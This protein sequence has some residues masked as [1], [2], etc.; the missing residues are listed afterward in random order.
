MKPD[1]L[2]VPATPS[3]YKPTRA[4]GGVEVGQQ[5]DVL[6]LSHLT[7]LL[8][9]GAHRSVAAGDV[10][11]PAGCIDINVIQDADQQLFAEIVFA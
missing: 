7:P 8:D 10:D 1:G 6:S 5:N 4:A 11:N 3:G 2:R 9:L